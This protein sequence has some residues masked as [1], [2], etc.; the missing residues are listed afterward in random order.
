M[1]RAWHPEELVE[2]WSVVPEDWPLIEPKQSATRLGFTVLL[3]FFQYAGSF[4]R[5]P[6]DVPLSVVEHLAQQVG[7]PADTWA[8][9]DWDSRTIERHRAQIRQHLG[10]REATVAD[11]EALV[12]WLCGQI[13][14]TTRRPEHLQEAVAQ[15][16][17]E[18]RIEPPTPERLD[19]L[20]RSA[21]HREDTRVGSE[22]LHRLSA[23][24]QGQ[25]EALLGPAEAPPSTSDD[26]TPPLARALLQELR[27]DPGRATLDNL[28]QE[29]AKLERIRALQLPPTLFDDIAPTVLQA[30]RQRVAVEEPYELRRHAL[31][32]RMTLLA[33]FCLLR[34]R[35]LTDILVDLL[36][37]LVHRLGAKAERKVEKALVD[38]LK[39]VHGKTGMLYRVA[40][41][42]LDH[43]TGV[44]RDVIFP[45]VSET[46]LRDLLKEWKAT[47]P[48]YRAHV[49]TVMRRAYR[50]HYRR[51]LPPLLATLAF[52]SNNATHQPLIR[53]LALLKQYLP[54]RVRTYPLEEDVPLEGV[55]REPWREAV[56]ETDAQGC[57]RVN[58][59]TYELCV[60]QTLRDQLRCK[61]IWVVGA[62]RYRNPDDDVPQDFAVR[63]ST[64]Y[65]ALKLPTQAADFIQQVQ[66]EMRDELAALDR[67]LP[68]NA[69]VT[70]LPK[71]KGWIKLSP[72]APQP[73]PRNL[74]ALKMEISKRWP[75]TSL[76][77]VLKETDLRVDFT[78]FFRSPT[79]W[80]NLDRATL[81]Y[82]LLLALYGLGTGAGLKRVALGNQTL[83][84]KELLYVRHRF[85]TPE[86]VR[87]SIAA[88]V[89]RL[90]ETRLP[91][92]WGEDIT[93]CASDSRHFRAWD[94]NLLTEWHARYGKP[95]IMIYWHVDRKAACIYSQLKTCASSEVAAMIEG[96]LRHC[97]TMEVDRQYVD[98]HGQSAVAFAFCHLLG[99]QLLP[100][101]KAIHK[102]RLYRPETGSPEAY[103][104]LQPV[105]RRPINWNLITPEYDNMIKYST[106]LRLG[107]AETDAILRRFTRHNVQHP[108]Y[109]A[110]LEL[111]KARRTIFLCRYLRLR[112]LRQEIHEGLNVVENWNSANDF[113]LFGKGGEIATNRREDQE[114]AMLALHLLQNALVYIN[115]LMLQR[116]LSETAWATRLTVEDLRALTPLLHAHVSP[117]GHFLLD[118]LTRLDIELPLD[119]GYGGDTAPIIPERRPP[120]SARRNRRAPAQ[121]L[122]LF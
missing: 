96:V 108:T 76:L 39:R 49:Q 95:G 52:R 6:Q 121:Q 45:V 86:A 47:G 91:H 60:L 17:R 94:Q 74:L 120:A 30:Y 104:N 53:A 28:F 55:I 78:R 48:F 25:L 110:L 99:F 80:E 46:T 62:D 43:P 97:T 73:E 89:N 40:E 115:T 84:Y 112:E 83:A 3:K 54:S 116:V 13:L 51:M 64:Y 11:S 34:G 57:Q 42:S 119:A 8:Q 103:P 24:T 111:G 36:L 27:A 29:I 72:L 23:T 5:A 2:H 58:R 59:L 118:M 56:M 85:I 92:L 81:Q 67:S 41:A 117:Y 63:R 101:L 44:V 19:R 35:D 88:I 79:A 38:D 75:M 68:R 4:P 50:S 37:E 9:Y 90:F 12:T 82:R 105:L 77:D 107:T 10:F 16:C 87:Q 1:K 31:P 113:I 65:A 21:V 14:L 102:Q 7:V 122:A 114:L 109:T 26:S 98:S 70:I 20:I 66:Q 15:R 69:D 93:A 32:L 71:A 106:A 100:R 33:A 18:L 22:I 61:E